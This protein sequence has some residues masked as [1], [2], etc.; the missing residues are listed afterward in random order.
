MNYFTTHYRLSYKKGL[1]LS[2]HRGQ[3]VP[4]AIQVGVG[5]TGDSVA[6][7]LSPTAGHGPARRHEPQKR[8]QKYFI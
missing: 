4:C 8:S 1:N 6:L 2:H 7:P 3:K 5:M